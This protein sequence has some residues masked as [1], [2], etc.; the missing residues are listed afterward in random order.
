MRFFFGRCRFMLLILLLPL[1]SG[2]FLV[3]Q[4]FLQQRKFLLIE[5]FC[6]LHQTVIPVLVHVLEDRLELHEI[7]VAVLRVA[8][9]ALS[10]G[11]VLGWTPVVQGRILHL[12]PLTSEEVKT[13]VVIVIVIIITHD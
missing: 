3:L 11:E 5:V 10:D 9:D 8:A 6:V 13:G 2:M 4:I 1:L 7:G 12:V